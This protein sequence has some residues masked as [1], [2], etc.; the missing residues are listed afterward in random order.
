M[1]LILLVQ[2]LD[3]T[4]LHKISI[5]KVNNKHPFQSNIC[6]NPASFVLLLECNIKMFVCPNPLY[7]F[8]KPSFT[9]VCRF[10]LWSVRESALCNVPC[11][12]CIISGGSETG[13]SETG[14]SETGG[15]PK[16]GFCP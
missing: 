13:E 11:I 2:I 9:V 8:T 1:N 14:V 10:N 7:L 3:K 12:D 16:R 5:Q 6:S 15:F 4:L